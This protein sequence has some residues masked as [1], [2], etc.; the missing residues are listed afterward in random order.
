MTYSTTRTFRWRFVAAC[1]ALVIAGIV[2]VL[3]T[4]TRAESSADVTT[5]S[6]PL[7][8]A[9]VGAEQ[10]AQAQSAFRAQFSLLRGADDGLPA[11]AVIQ[12]PGIDRA[13]AHEIALASPSALER[14]GAGTPEARLWVAP[15]NDGTQCLLAQPADAQGPAV[16]CSEVGV[17]SDGYLLM[18]QSR[19]ASDVELYGLLPD[20]VSAVEVSFVDGSSTTLPVAENAYAAHFA[21]ATTSIAFTDAKGVEHTL[22]AGIAG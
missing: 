19:S 4:S 12:D 22:D 15:R 5:K 13:A 10:D 16:V 18:T 14:A 9:A 20:G 11:A 2:A 21:K 1:A 17:A 6:A 7:F 3:A 8:P